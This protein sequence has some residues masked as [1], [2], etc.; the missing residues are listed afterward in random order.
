[1]QCVA[2]TGINREVLEDLARN[3]VRTIELR[4][5]HNIF[6]VV[7]MSLGDTVFLTF[8]SLH[9]ISSGTPG[10]LALVRSLDVRMHRVTGQYGALCC[11]E[12]ETMYARVQVVLRN[13]GKVRRTLPTSM[14]GPTYV[15]VDEQLFYK[16]Q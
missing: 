3:Q 10:L 16:A 15:E 7:N 4:S 1:M 11:E 14:G 12:R 8:T 9:D 13:R 5:A 2:L 6:S